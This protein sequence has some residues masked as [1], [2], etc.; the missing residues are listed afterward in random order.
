MRHRLQSYYE[1]DDFTVN[2]TKKPLRKNIKYFTYKYSSLK[3]ARKL[4]KI[5]IKKDKPKYNYVSKPGSNKM[6]KKKIKIKLKMTRP[7]KIKKKVNKK[8]QYNKKLL[9]QPVSRLNEV[10]YNVKS[11]SFAAMIIFI[12]FVILMLWGIKQYGD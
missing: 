12:I 7:K 10:G 5:K 11:T 6:N 2:K 3:K 1:K 9:K 4:E 8:I